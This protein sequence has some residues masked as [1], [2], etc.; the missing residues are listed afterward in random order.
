L[1]NLFQPPDHVGADVQE[2]TT[3]V[4]RSDTFEGGIHVIKYDGGRHK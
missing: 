3:Y 2:I 1:F 4:P